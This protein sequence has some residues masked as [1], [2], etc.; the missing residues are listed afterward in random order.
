[1]S[2]P[3]MGKRSRDDD[4]SKE[5]EP[6]VRHNSDGNVLYRLDGVDVYMNRSHSHALLYVVRTGH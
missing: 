2:S 3:T 6:M 1:M 4:G 5:P